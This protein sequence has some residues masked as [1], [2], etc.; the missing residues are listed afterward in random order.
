MTPHLMLKPFFLVVFVIVMTGAFIL[1][2]VQPPVPI[3]KADSSSTLNS[4]TLEFD[5]HFKEIDV[6]KFSEIKDVTTKKRTYF[7]FIGKLAAEN[8]QLILRKRSFIQHLRDEYIDYIQSNPDL[9]L[10]DFN[11]QFL[12]FSQQQKLQFLMTEYRVNNKKIADLF[13]ELLLR[14]NTIP[15]E[16]IQV[17]T[18]NESGWGTSRFAVQGYNFFGLWC[19]ETGCGFVPK[20]RAEGMTHEV[21]K[22]S[23]PAQGMYRYVRN[24]NRNRAYR[25]LRIKRLSLSQASPS[26][27]FQHAME[28]TTTLGSYSERGQDYIDELQSMLRVNRSLLGLVRVTTILHVQGSETNN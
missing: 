14:V 21:A 6:P 2:F 16:L 11:T 1:P 24:L 20:K 4:F 13:S 22:F 8:N 3:I 17:Q 19:Y 23:T 26:L 7:E 25:Q 10:Q 5:K 27:S 12:T 28:L 18:A 9:S 15:V